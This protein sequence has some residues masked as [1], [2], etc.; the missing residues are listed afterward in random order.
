MGYWRAMRL[1]Q[2]FFF[3]FLRKGRTR[4]SLR[5]TTTCVFCVCM[6]GVCVRVCVV[7]LGASVGSQKRKR[8]I[9]RL[10]QE[11]QRAVGGQC[12][13]WSARTNKQERPR[14]TV[15]LFLLVLR[16]FERFLALQAK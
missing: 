1:N 16:G 9:Q 7:W 12:V 13:V 2:N 15:S 6:C 10:K 5:T 14:G 11:Y 8:Y 3:F 4:N